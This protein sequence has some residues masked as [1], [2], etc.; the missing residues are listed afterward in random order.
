M[1]HQ[2]NMRVADMPEFTVGTVTKQMSIMEIWVET[3]AQEMMRLTD[4][5]ITSLKHD[6][7]GQLFVDRQT[8]DACAP[9]MVYQ[10][11]DDRQT[12][13]SVQVTANSNACSV[14]VPATFPGT[15]TTSGTATSD[16][17]GSEPLIMWSTLSGS[18][19]EYSLGSPVAV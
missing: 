17:V 16:K 12:I 13:T 19:V 5:P 6:D 9:K 4:W 15:A 8:L 10:L 2:A 1:F 3:I 11:S 18:A 7:I 14:P